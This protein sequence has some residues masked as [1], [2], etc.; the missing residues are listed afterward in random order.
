[1]HITNDDQFLITASDD[2]SV[3]CWKIT[4]KEGR[5]MKRDKEVGWAEEILIT[6]SDLEEKV[7][8]RGKEDDEVVEKG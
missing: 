6:K 4:D 1:M 3:V 8:T 2:A 7:S 5:G